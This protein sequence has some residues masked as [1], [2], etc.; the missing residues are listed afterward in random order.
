MERMI[1][2]ELEVLTVIFDD[3]KEVWAD[4]DFEFNKKASS[5]YK[6]NKYTI[7]KLYQKGLLMKDTSCCGVCFYMITDK[8]KEALKK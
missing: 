7:T 3:S 6:R 1:E 4:K 2:Q 5:Y 8:G